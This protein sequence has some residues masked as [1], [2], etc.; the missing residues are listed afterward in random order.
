M[1]LSPDEL[2][3][4]SKKIFYTSV[5]MFVFIVINFMIDVIFGKVTLAIVSIVILVMCLTYIG[6]KLIDTYQGRSE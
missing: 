6:N 4:V 2:T 5:V 1:I 3:G